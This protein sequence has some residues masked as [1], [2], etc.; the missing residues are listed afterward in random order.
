MSSGLIYQRVTGSSPS[1][2]T[3]N[4]YQAKWYAANKPLQASRVRAIKQLKRLFV[5]ALKE[6]HPCTDCGKF[7][8][9]CQMQFDHIANDKAFNIAMSYSNVGWDKLVEEIEK[10]ELVC[11]NCHAIRTYLRLHHTN[12]I[13]YA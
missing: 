5:N 7:Y 9:P 8:Y 12:K 2:P 3:N 13:G 1:S 10:C 6:N 4:Q 11:A